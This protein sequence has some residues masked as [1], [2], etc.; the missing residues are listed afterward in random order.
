MARGSVSSLT[1]CPSPPSLFQPPFCGGEIAV[2]GPAAKSA[3]TPSKASPPQPRAP[4]AE[5][6]AQPESIRTSMQMPRRCQC[7]FLRGEAAAMNSRAVAAKRHPRQRRPSIAAPR[8]G[9]G[10]AGAVHS[11]HSPPR[12]VHFFHHGM[13]ARKMD[14]ANLV[15]SQMAWAL[16]VRCPNRPVDRKHLVA[17]GLGI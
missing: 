10:G 3:A 1:G 17:N 5:P 9:A 11:T 4:N 15:V 7:L 13:R 2:P 16:N 14:V 12:A 8:S 6:P